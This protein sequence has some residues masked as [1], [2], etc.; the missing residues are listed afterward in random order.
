MDVLIRK[1]QVYAFLRL[2]AVDEL[3]CLHHVFTICHRRLEKL[4]GL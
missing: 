2:D 4:L 3:L 1:Q